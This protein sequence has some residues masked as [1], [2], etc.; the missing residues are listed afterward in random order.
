MPSVPA[1]KFP[2]Q[3]KRSWH[4]VT[5]GIS[6]VATGVELLRRGKEPLVVAWVTIASGVAFL[7]WFGQPAWRRAPM[8]WFDDKGLRARVP[9]FGPLPWEHIE[10]LRFVRINGKAFLVIDRVLEERQKRSLGMLARAVARQA[11][12]KDLAVPLDG[13]AAAPDKVFAIVDLAHRHMTGAVGG[14]GVG[15]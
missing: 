6:I 4:F 14:R 7:L 11:E 3:A 15:A 2:M 9:G 1:Q 5:V 10:R 13:L 12:A 8:I